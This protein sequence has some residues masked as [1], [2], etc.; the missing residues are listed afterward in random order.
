[1]SVN[2][3]K[4]SDILAARKSSGLTQDALARRL[5]TSKASLSKWERDLLQPRRQSALRLA[6]WISMQP[7]PRRDG[8]PG[9][10]GNASAG[11]KKIDV[12]VMIDPDLADKALAEGLDLN[13]LADKALREAISDAKAKRWQHENLGVIAAWNQELEENGLWSD[14][15]RQF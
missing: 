1:M 10:V 11:R 14:G 9:I 5:G 8:D 6:E 3:L 13:V 4:G 7:F 2:I 15:L 12:E